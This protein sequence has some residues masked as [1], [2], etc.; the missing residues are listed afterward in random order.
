MSLAQT[1]TASAVL[2]DVDNTLLDNDRVTADLRDH[3]EAATRPLRG[4]GKG[5]RRLPTSRLHNRAHR[6]FIEAQPSAHGRR[7]IS[8]IT[9]W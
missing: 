9:A 1:K 4:R 7:Q 2:F 5:D 3:L 8:F 6:G